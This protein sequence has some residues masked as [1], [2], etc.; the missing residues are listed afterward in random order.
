[1]KKKILAIIMAAMMA[2][3]IFGCTSYQEAT[4]ISKEG[5]SLA[6]GILR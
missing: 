3:L 2:L 1:M 5:K 4:D 6:V